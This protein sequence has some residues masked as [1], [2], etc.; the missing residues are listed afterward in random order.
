MYP[1][2]PVV[3]RY[4][5]GSHTRLQSM[6]ADVLALDEGD[7]E[8][9]SGP[10]AEMWFS[11][12]AQWPSMVDL[13]GGVRAPLT[14]L[15]RSDPE[16][17]VGTRCSERFGPVLPYLLKVISA[18]TPLSLQVHPVDFEAR[19]GFNFET[20]LGRPIEDPDRAFKDA[21]AKNEM[22]VALEPFEASVGFAS[23]A[24][25]L[26]NLTLVDHPVAKRMVR[27]LTKAP[28]ER[29]GG[30]PS[31]TQASDF[32]AADAMMPI[33]AMVWPESRK[34][35]FRAFH[36]AVTADSETGLEPALR[37]ARATVSDP[38]STLAFDNALRACQT[39]EG[40]P[41]VLALLMMNPVSLQEGDSVFIAAG[42]PHAYISGTGI[43]IMT[44]SDNVLRAG[45][46][47]KS[48]DIP[49]FMK[50]LDCSCGAPVNP[51]VSRFADLGTM[52]GNRVFYR[53]RISEFALAYGRVGSGR[54]PWPVWEKITQRYDELPQV[55]RR[56]PRHFGPR[57]IVCTEGSVACASA[58]EER[59]LC[60][61]DAIFVPASDGRV[62]ISVAGGS[63]TRAGRRR[64]EASPTGS[65]VYACT[66][67]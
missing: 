51:T 13:G 23:P 4:A 33:A 21:V 56:A 3:K 59:V 58:K 37:K 61:G 18:G 20:A 62:T 32:A 31:V 9:A 55:S 15:I 26:A 64:S 12:H 48:K 24:F 36:T 67:V 16:A 8:P 2:H 42:T 5:W 34:R 6:F 60:Q 29:T 22:V 1:I 19:A 44:N 35:V 25:M 54:R 47:V 17:M 27:A 43:E 65:F 39:F 66:Q 41:S 57:I 63:P 10:I 46:T 38:R 14:D 7:A 52:F 53:P 30:G 50:S 28:S 45:M 49:D 11:G 40:D